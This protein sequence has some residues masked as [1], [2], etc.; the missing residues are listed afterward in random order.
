[1]SEGAA[2]GAAFPWKIATLGQAFYLVV[3][4]YS[5]FLKGL[6]GLTVT[7]GSILTLAMLMRMT[8][9]INWKEVFGAKKDR[10]QVAA[11]VGEVG[12]S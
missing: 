12:S 9:G 1:M 7:I 10:R 8:A 2:L 11:G 3:F 4:S 5:F 6:T